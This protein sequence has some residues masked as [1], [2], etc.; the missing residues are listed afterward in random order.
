M[1]LRNKIEELCKAAKRP[2]CDSD[3]IKR[4]KKNRVKSN[5]V[6]PSPSLIVLPFKLFSILL[7]FRQQQ[8]Q[9]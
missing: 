3:F 4:K 7:I 9:A 2:Q 1:I 8:H 6:P 5:V